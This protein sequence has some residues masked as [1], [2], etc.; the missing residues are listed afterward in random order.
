MFVSFTKL[1]NMNQKACDATGYYQPTPNGTNQQW[2][3]PILWG[4]KKTMLTENNMVHIKSIFI[5]KV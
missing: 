2:V 4:K 5:S 1:E 3:L